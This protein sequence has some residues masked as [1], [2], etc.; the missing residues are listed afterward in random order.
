MFSQNHCFRC[1]ISFILDKMVLTV[2]QRTF[3]VEHTFRCNGQ[4]TDEVRKR[5]EEA[6]PNED[7]PYRN[8]VRSL[9]A[10]FRETGS[11]HDADRSGRPSVLNAEKM[12][13]ISEAMTNS[14]SKSLL[15][16]SQEA[17]ISLGSAHNAVRKNLN[18]YPYKV[19]CY[20]ELKDTDYEK[21][22]YCR[23]FGHV[24]DDNGVLNRTFFSDEA[25]FH[26]SGYVNSQ[27]SR[28]WST[29]NPHQF[30]ESSLHSDKVGV[31]CAM[32]R[33]RIIGPIFFHHTI[34]AERYWDEVILPFMNELSRQER[35]HGY[36][37]QDGAPPHTA[38]VNLSRLKEAFPS[39][40]IS[41]GIWPPR[42]P[43][44]SPLDFYLWGTVKEKVFKRKPRNLEEI[45][46]HISEIIQV[47]TQEELASVFNNMK[48]RIE[49]CIRENGGHFQQFL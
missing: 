5:F 47:I 23:W 30:I 20:H 38:S 36:F 41:T 13:A 16:L 9:I 3:L 29:V 26:L 15:R 17:D 12:D 43:D 11:V 31:W 8:S 14:P 1:S 48:K 2:Q 7:P 27:N 39:R 35:Q 6:F 24:L 10:K 28:H 45:Q 22:V 49:L 44:L 37:Q 19:T 25:W 46:Q 34:N 40:L 18:L 32:S 33:R 21:R 42:S 4:C